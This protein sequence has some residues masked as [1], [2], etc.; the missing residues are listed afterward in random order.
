MDSATLSTLAGLAGAVIGGATSFATTWLATTAQARASKRA[1]D[2]AARQD[3]YGRYMDE[4]AALYAAAIRSETVDFDRTA[5]AFALRGRIGLMASPPVAEAAERALKFVVD[6]SMGPK[7]GE[8]EVRAMMDD[9]EA[10]VIDA[11]ASTCRAEM[12]ASA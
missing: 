11:F 5:S 6:L 10:N 12:Q 4:L 1:A 9:A 2:R 7:R 8:R 3:L